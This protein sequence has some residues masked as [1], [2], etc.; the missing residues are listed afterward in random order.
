[1]LNLN[2]YKNRLNRKNKELKRINNELE[3]RVKIEI[4]KQMEQ[5]KIVFYQSK[6]AS[7]GEMISMIAHQWRQPLTAISSASGD[8]KIKYELDMLNDEALM[9]NIDAIIHRTQKMS[10][11]INDFMNFFKPH[12]D[13]EVFLLKALFD[14]ILKL[15]KPQFENR[16]IEFIINIDKNI[17]IN[18][19]KNELEQVLLNILSNARDAYEDK[20]TLNKSVEIFVKENKNKKL[21]IFIKD[22]AGGI[23]DGFLNKIF[24]PYITTKEEG[25]GTG[26]G[27]YM[28]KTIIQRSFKGDISAENYYDKNLKSKKA[29]GAIFNILISIS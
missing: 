2:I 13:K 3:D 23:K 9:S 6:M 1:M 10:E 21:N 8:I 5:E 28:S 18:G 26:I 11:T 25:K 17:T 15:I 27:L 29:I 20:K 24:E 14:E 12:K 19:Y 7:M 4:K 16:T 22:K